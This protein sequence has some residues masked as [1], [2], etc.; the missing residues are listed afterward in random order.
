MGEKLEDPEGGLRAGIGGPI[1]ES[2]SLWDGFCA[3]LS[4]GPSPLGG[5]FLALG[6]RLDM[7]PIKMSKSS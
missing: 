2:A 3:G 6:L 5:S 1:D 4:G 7:F